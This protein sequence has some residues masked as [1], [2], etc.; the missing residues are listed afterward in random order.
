MTTTTKSQ[1]RRYAD[2]CAASHALNLVGERWALLIVRELLLGPKRFGR[3]R[4]DLPGLSA[5][6]LTQRLRE[7]EDGG[8]VEVRALPAPA[9]VQV[10]ALTEWGEELWPVLEQLVVWGFKSP[11]FPGFATMSATSFMLS[12][13]AFFDQEAASDVTAL[14]EIECDGLHFAVRI[15]NGMLAIATEPAPGTDLKISATTSLL[16]RLLYARLPLADLQADGLAWEG[17]AALLRR[18][19]AIFPA[20]DFRGGSSD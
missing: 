4:Q 5:N 9:S 13:K 10:Y 11:D 18:L 7:L 19:P 3:L 14:V 20:R 1:R 8:V 16:K 2:G 6:I 12:L 15:A 17:D